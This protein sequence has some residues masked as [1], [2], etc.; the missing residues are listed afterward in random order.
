[1]DP[2]VGE[3]PEAGVDAVDRVTT[4]DGGFDRPAGRGHCRDGVRGDRNAH[5]VAGDGDD[6]RDRE[7]ATVYGDRAWHAGGSYC[8]EIRDAKVDAEID[9]KSTRLNS[10][11]VSISYAVFC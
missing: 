10:S 2:H 11:H 7:G 1:L 5:A 8:P 3:L 4:S 6:V 9:R